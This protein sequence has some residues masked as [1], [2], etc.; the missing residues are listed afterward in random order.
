MQTPIPALTT[1]QMREVDRLMEE[2]YG[3]SLIQMMENAGR[4]LAALGRRTLGGAVAGKRV[5]ALCGLGGNGGGG[6]VAARHLANWGAD[7]DV[8]LAGDESR[9]K[10]V[11]A[12][13]WAIVRRLGLD[14]EDADPA[15][16]DLVLDAMLGYGTRGDPR[17]PIASWIKRANASG[18]PVQ[19]LDAPSGLDTTS[20]R[21]GQPCIRAIATMTLA[22]PKTGLLSPEAAD[23]VGELYLADISV[24]P[25]LYAD[26]GLDL[27]AI[28]EK[29]AILKLG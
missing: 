7:V 11:P 2:D 6:M 25:A 19:A 22:L 20:G 27:G 13:Q 15:A 24:P 1:E 16:A 28:F 21:P 10:A 26:M 12:H 23:H 17:P 18:T 5:L 4:N 29:E 8:I 14:V 3:I 9:L